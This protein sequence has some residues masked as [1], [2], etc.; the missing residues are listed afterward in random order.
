MLPFMASPFD[1]N[2]SGWINV[3]TQDLIKLI[4]SQITDLNDLQPD[5]NFFELG[6]TS[7]QVVGLVAEIENIFG[8]RFPDSMINLETFSSVNSIN[9]G[10]A[11]LTEKA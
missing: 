2:S 3:Y 5:H 9:N 7:L 1:K 11:K 4:T 6:I 8:V 10:L